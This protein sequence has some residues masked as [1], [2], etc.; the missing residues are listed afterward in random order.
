MTVVA[1]GAGG[2]ARD[3]GKPLPGFGQAEHLAERRNGIGR[4]ETHEVQAG[5]RPGPPASVPR[6]TMKP[7]LEVIGLYLKNQSRPSIKVSSKKSYPPGQ[8]RS[9]DLPTDPPLASCKDLMQQQQ[10]PRRNGWPVASSGPGAGKRAWRPGPGGR[11]FLDAV[12][13]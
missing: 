1:P 7:L 4:L 13:G 9:L 6:F 10:Q 3:A 8:D 12:E 2:G 11:W 5:E